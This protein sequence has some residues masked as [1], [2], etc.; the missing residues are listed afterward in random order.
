MVPRLVLTIGEYAA[1]V[2]CPA[3]LSKKLPVAVAGGLRGRNCGSYHEP[4]PVRK[5]DFP[6]FD[7]SALTSH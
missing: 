1:H 3:V 2:G 6:D 4:R 7:R 5:C